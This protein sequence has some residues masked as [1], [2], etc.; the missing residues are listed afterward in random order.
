MARRFGR[1]AVL[2]AL[3]GSGASQPHLSKQEFAEFIHF[4]RDT[5]RSRAPLLHL[6]T[7]SPET[8]ANFLSRFPFVTANHRAF[9]DRVLMV[10]ATEIVDHPDFQH[11]PGKPAATLPA[12]TGKGSWAF[13]ALVRRS[14]GLV[15]VDKESQVLAYFKHWTDGLI[16][17]PGLSLA[18]RSVSPQSAHTGSGD[19]RSLGSLPVRL[20]AVVNRLDL[21][22]L[23]SGTRNDDRAPPDCPDSM[24]CGAEFRFVYGSAPEWG[25]ERYSLIL[26]FVLPPL[27]KKDFKDLAAEW[28]GLI[29]PGSTDGFRNGLERV[30]G[31][32]F[33]R[34]SGVSQG[35]APLIRIRIN[36]GDGPWRFEEYHVTKKGLMKYPLAREPNPGTTGAPCIQGGP[37][38]KFAADNESRVLLSTYDWPGAH[39]PAPGIATCLI[40]L[41]KPPAVALTL[42][43]ASKKDAL[44]YALSINSC[45]GCHG[46][47][48]RSVT[49]MKGSDFNFEQIR[50]R[51]SGA[52]SE[53]SSFLTGDSQAFGEPTVEYG[54]QEITGCGNQTV[55]AH[56]FNDLLR[57]HI[58]MLAAEALGDALEMKE[59][60]RRLPELGQAAEAAMDE[61]E[62][63]LWREVLA[64]TGLTALQAH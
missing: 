34:M 27:T 7:V 57:R 36:S 41:T 35:G 26:E 3:A 30:L 33:A 49:T 61:G 11:E 29:D 44:R 16:I 32:C 50:N 17:N 55:A 45:S 58:F 4:L 19:S 24:A 2:L 28:N 5:A 59:Q 9:A 12:A 15:G 13:P 63:E 60:A 20:L 47:E 53:L 40:Q 31:D 38:E 39:C 21:A 25:T 42:A 43:G 14:F 10:R 54:S 64:G 8:M 22:G 37:L 56:G 52:P 1:L 48:T 46:P 23:G 51:A 6:R 18:W 62:D